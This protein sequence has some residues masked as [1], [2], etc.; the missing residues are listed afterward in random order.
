MTVALQ[1]VVVGAGY[2][3]EFHLQ[4]WQRLANTR[5]AAIVELDPVKRTDLASRFPDTVITDTFAG[6][7]Q[8]T[9]ADIVDIITPPA[10][11]EAQIYEAIQLTESA[12]IICQKPFCGTLNAASLVTQY[13]ERHKRTVIVHENF[14]F[15]PW[16]AEIKALITHGELGQVLQAGFRLRPGDGQ[17]ADAYLDRQPYFRSMSR[18]LIHE[19]GVHWVDVYRYLFGEPHAVSA[20]LRNINK[21]IAGEDAGYF[22]LHYENGLR[23]H[24]DGNRLLDHNAR[25]TRLTLGEM[26]VE[27]T[28]GSLH[29]SG[30]G[31][32]TLR[33]FNSR[34]SIPHH[35]TFTD[36]GF[37]G[38]CV[39]RLQQHVVQHVLDGTHLHN[40]ATDYMRNLELEELIYQ[41]AATQQTQQYS[42]T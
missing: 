38:D 1:V 4:A 32:I 34:E 7:L 8:Q 15:Q 29:L 3:G 23:A 36:E 25:N 12:L 13:I 6:A 22:V 30:D 20:D 42:T 27:G 41:A 37:G 11:H 33:R 26:L 10:S 28:D 14:R 24:F 31:Q 35:Y 5:L 18:F 21:S 39:Y 19:T 40:R 17:G 2:F 16:Y 9:G